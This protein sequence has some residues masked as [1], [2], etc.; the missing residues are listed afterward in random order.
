M[1]GEYSE[2]IAEFESSIEVYKAPA[3]LLAIN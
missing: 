3:Q 1:A 2:V